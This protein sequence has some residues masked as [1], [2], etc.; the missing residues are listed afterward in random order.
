[1]KIRNLTPHAVVF[2]LASGT[3]T[4]VAEIP[5]PR[6]LMGIVASEDVDGVPTV[7]SSAGDVF[8]LPEGEMG[9]VLNVSQIIAQ[10]RPERRDLYFP[11]GIIRDGKG[12][13]VGCSRLARVPAHRAS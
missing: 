2:Q 8:D 11:D 5:C 6:V 10:A 4:I 3:R 13:I 12:V 1:M 9:V 7:I